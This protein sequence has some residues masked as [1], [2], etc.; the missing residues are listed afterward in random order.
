MYDVIVIGAGQAGLASAHAL[1]NAGLSF[2]VL[3]S[4]DR[5]A[6]SWPRY[7]DSLKLFSPARHSSLPGLPFHG[8][9]ERYPLRD[10]V[11]QYLE[12]YARHFAFPIAYSARVTRISREGNHFHI[13]TADGSRWLARTVISASGPYNQPN[14]P[15]FDGLDQFSGKIVHSA[16]YRNRADVPGTRVAVVGSGNS[17]IQIAHEL[18]RTHQVVV[19]AREQPRL[20]RQ[21]PWGRD[22][23]DWLTLS[24]VDTLPVGRW[25][26]WSPTTPVLDSGVYRRAFA[27]G[28]LAY[29]PL[30]DRV[31]AQ[32]LRWGEQEEQF[33]TLVMATGF[34]NQPDYLAGLDGMDAARAAQQKGGRAVH[35][36]G[37]YFVGTAWQQSN[38]SATLRGV[39]RDA[40]AVVK[41]IVRQL[42]RS[43]FCCPFTNTLGSCRRV[44]CS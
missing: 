41:H 42:K 19:S 10:E 36:H 37:L 15:E 43:D 28:A 24:G 40:R 9:P 13:E 22:I 20:V 29:R 8:D 4:S 18:S 33:D 31:T 39:G 26:G 6:G 17:A 38:A 30:F 27:E 2:H 34:V 5:A 44:F 23:H 21:R 16:D 25:F 14:I 32:G 3:E 35:V 11:V 12:D 1:Q 7:Y